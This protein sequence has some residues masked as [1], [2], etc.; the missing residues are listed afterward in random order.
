[1]RWCAFLLLAV[2]LAGCHWHQG[3]LGSSRKALHLGEET[4]AVEEIH[5]QAPPQKIVIDGPS[6]CAEVGE[7]EC[8][9]EKGP[10]RPKAKEPTEKAG[11]AGARGAAQQAPSARAGAATGV[12]PAGGAYATQSQAIFPTG[13]F[14]QT[15]ALTAPLAT[16]RPGSSGLGIGLGFIN[17]PIPVPRFFRI[18]EQPTLQVPLSQAQIIA[19][20]GFQG[21]GVAGNPLLQRQLLLQGQR[22]REEAD[23][24][25]L[26]L[27]M[28][29]LRQQQAGSTRAGAG[30][31][32]G[33]AG[34][35]PEEV[36]KLLEQLEAKQAQVNALKG[37]V[38]QV[39]A[40]LE[41]LAKQ[42]EQ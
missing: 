38:A 26:V 31:K 40:L 23:L 18:Q 5:I 12:V 21:G 32:A 9:A 1:M 35:S 22:G 13:A 3:V 36:K 24:E 14:S 17:I 29:L 20:G 34:A 11:A 33:A 2:P 19:A 27:L 41:Q 4:E 39:K 7:R 16:T 10:A 37:E 42:K 30:K 15:S 6:S 25:E 28:Q 8:P